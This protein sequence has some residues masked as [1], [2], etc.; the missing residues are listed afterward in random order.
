MEDVAELPAEHGVAG[1]G[2]PV[3]NRPKGLRSLLVVGAQDAR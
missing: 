3:D 1:Q 2:Q